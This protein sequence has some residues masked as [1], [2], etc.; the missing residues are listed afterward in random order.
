MPRK[1]ITQ[2]QVA[3]VIVELK[4]AGVADPSLRLIRNKLGRGS[5]TSIMRHKQALEA[6][7]V[8]AGE[9][10]LPD[11]LTVS[12]EKASRALWIE[13]AQ[14]ADDIVKNKQEALER[15]Q[16]T[17][18]KKIEMIDANEA[19]LRSKVIDREKQINN[20]QKQ[21]WTSES[22]RLATEKK[23]AKVSGEQTSLTVLKSALT[24]E[25]RAHQQLRKQVDKERAGW[26]KRLD[27][28]QTKY[29]KVMVMAGNRARKSKS[30]VST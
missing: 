8:K 21:L 19:V 22:K 2:K 27:Q 29:E 28:L 13:L 16:N 14:A 18:D 11:A 7:A 1:G 6:N 9:E 26:L 17:I 23:L 30:T 25:K 4:G 5:L 20:L 3:E 12:I 24:Q 15:Q 10:R